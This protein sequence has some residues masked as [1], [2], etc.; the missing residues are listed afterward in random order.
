LV[1][2]RVALTEAMRFR[3]SLRLAITDPYANALA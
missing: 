3:R 2:L 1:I